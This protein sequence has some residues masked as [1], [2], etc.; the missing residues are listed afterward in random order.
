MR[1]QLVPLIIALSIAVC[2]SAQDPV[3]SPSIQEVLNRPV[4]GISAGRMR[5][6][7]LFTLAFSAAGIPGGLQLTRCGR[8][9]ASID[10]P[11]HASMKAIIEKAVAAH[12]RSTVE[13]TKSGVLNL[14]LPGPRAPLLE[15]HIDEANIEMPNRDSAVAVAALL[16]LPEVRLASQPFDLTEVATEQGFSHLPNPGAAPKVEH[17]LLKDV[18]VRDAL[19]DIARRLGHGFWIYEEDPCAEKHTFVI[20]FC[21]R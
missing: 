2:G 16:A 11:D 13:V 10:A 20:S 6:T 17:I 7:D 3:P 8:Q 21:V 15:T 1:H 19:N 5:I 9:E 14:S 4:P 18:T 12:P